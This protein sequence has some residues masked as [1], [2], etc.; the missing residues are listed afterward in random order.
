MQTRFIFLALAICLEWHWTLP[1]SSFINCLRL[2][3]G[4]EFPMACFRMSLLAM[5]IIVCHLSLSIPHFS[6]CSITAWRAATASRCWKVRTKCSSQNLLRVKP[7]GRKMLW[8]RKLKQTMC[9]IPSVAL[10]GTLDGMTCL[11]RPMSSS[12]SRKP[13][14]TTSA[15]IILVIPRRSWRWNQMQPLKT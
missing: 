10:W 5:T 13:M 14:T 4:Q 1:W 12:A 9:I 2:N 11:R 15:W 6:S 8:E 3:P 7:S